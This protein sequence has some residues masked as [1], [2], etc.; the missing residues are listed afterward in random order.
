[1]LIKRLISI[2]L[3]SGFS[4]SDFNIF[5]PTQGTST[6]TPQPKEDKNIDELMTQIDK[7]KKEVQEIKNQK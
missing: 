3:E 2:K 4:E 6:K 7:L 1:L 5:N